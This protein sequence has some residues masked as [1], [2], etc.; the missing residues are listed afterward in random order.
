MFPWQSRLR[1][2]PARAGFTTPS[3]SGRSPGSDHPRSRGV[4][5]I[6]QEG[7]S[8]PPG[9]SPLARGL[10]GGCV[11]RHQSG[12]IIPARAGFTDYD[13]DF[14]P[15]R[16]DHPRSRGVYRDRQGRRILRA[17]SSPL[18]RGL[19]L[20]A[21]LRPSFTHGSSPL[22]RGL[23]YRP[24]AGDSQLRIIPARAG[25]TARVPRGRAPVRIIPARAG[26]TGGISGRRA[27][28]PDHPRSRG[29]YM[30]GVSG[31][32]VAIG[33]SPLARGLRQVEGPDGSRRRIIPAR[34][35]FTL[36]YSFDYCGGWDHPRSRGVYFR[37]PRRWIRPRG[38]SPLARGLPSTPTSTRR[39]ARIIP[40]RAGFTSW[41]RS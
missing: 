41:H 10:P 34:A 18:A 19:P 4:Y 11:R 29:V 1:I 13:H 6:L 35:G 38:S 12:R 30:R 22:A 8:P 17:G 31:H 14:R 2:I 5:R 37:G 23:Q 26:F 27:W 20:S 15:R 16:A 33:S 24:S 9:S 25:F 32:G 3:S 28:M 21:F 40:A 39:T 36:Q 7:L